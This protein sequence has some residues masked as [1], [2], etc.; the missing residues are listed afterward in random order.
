MSLLPEDLS[1]LASD[2]F[3]EI[4]Q[5]QQGYTS[6][7][8]LRAIATALSALPGRKTIVFFSEGLPLRSDDVRE[9]FDAMIE[10]ANRAN[11]SIYPVD[12][13]G[14]RIHSQDVASGRA[15]SQA[16]VSDLD[17]AIADPGS[18]AGGGAALSRSEAVLRGGS[19][20]HI[21][22]RLAKET[23]GFV[24]ENT[25]DLAGGF[26]RID[27]DR[28]FHYLLTYTPANGEFNGEYRRIEVK[29]KRRGMNVRAR[30]GYAAVHAPGTIPTL[31][32]EAPALAALAQTPRP[33][34]IPSTVRV[35]RLPQP[36]APGRVA[37]AIRV[38]AG[39]VTLRVNEGT[40][41]YE[42]DL[43]V[44]ARITDDKGNVVR[45]GSQPYRL[46]GPADEIEAARAEDV[47]FFR[48]PELPPGAY[49]VEYAVYDALSSK[50]GAGSLP[51][52]VQPDAPGLLQVGDLVLLDKAEQILESELDERNPLIVGDVLLYPV[53]ADALAAGTNVPL[54]FYVGIRPDRTRPQ[55]TATVTLTKG[56]QTV[57]AGPLGV[58]PPGAD[59]RIHQMSRITVDDLSPGE[60]ALAVSVS[61]GASTQNR[62]VRFVVRRTGPE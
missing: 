7:N 33:D 8:A 57:A 41:T 14:L 18:L 5:Q 46:S 11:V 47:V 40:A 24:I 44:V 58:S 53:L 31:S 6:I 23:G 49:T 25:N 19:T 38:P 13:V 39:A 28:R 1:G 29:V 26:R 35:L 34:A 17:T 43:T 56:G 27:A 42:S 30:R 37:L 21:F 15:I 12:T 16:S 61:D 59:G 48:T 50:A 55:V 60:Y 62:S 32:Y 54:A 2:Q 36:A 3:R 4:E 20:T 10:H 51:L 22:G 52:T 45:K 9:R